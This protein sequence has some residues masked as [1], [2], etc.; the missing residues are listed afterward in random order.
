MSSTLSTYI[1][2]RGLRFHAPVGVMEQ[3]R[4]VGNDIVVDLRIGYPFGRSMTTDDV[5]DT[6]NYADVYA[7]V[8]REVEQP[9]GLLERLAGKIAECL[10]KTYPG[11]TSIDMTITKVNP[12]MGADCEGAAVE[13]HLINTKTEV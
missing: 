11:I 7:I 5:A 2:L 1:L 3:E 8:S 10:T 6:L 12:P 9:V 13:I 4:E